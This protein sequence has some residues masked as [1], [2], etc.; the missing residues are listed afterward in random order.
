MREN[1]FAENGREFRR[2]PRSHNSTKGRNAPE[3]RAN[4]AP[5][6]TAGRSVR[7]TNACGARIPEAPPAIKAASR[8]SGARCEAICTDKWQTWFW[9][10]G[11]AL[12]AQILICRPAKAGGR[13]QYKADQLLRSNT[14]TCTGEQCG[15]ASQGTRSRL[16]RSTRAGRELS[17]R[18]RENFW[19]KNERNRRE[20]R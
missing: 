19:D 18:E 15:L 13:A 12:R 10:A 2:P 14:H 1:G 11:R 5:T 16:A 17:G 3:P 6:V 8:L 9:S 4:V 7:R 20:R